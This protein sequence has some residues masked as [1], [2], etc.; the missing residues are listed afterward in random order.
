MKRNIL[1]A[2]FIVLT[3]T[4]HAQSPKYVSPTKFNDVN[5]QLLSL[6]T[7]YP[8]IAIGEGQHNSALTAEWL[9]SFIH[10]KKFSTKVRNIVVE[11]G[12][13]KYQAVMDDFVNGKPVP[14]SLFRLCWRKT[15]QILVWDCPIYEQFFREVRT[16][17]LSLPVT[18]RIRVLLGDPPDFNSLSRDE[19]AFNVIEK[20]V[21]EKKQTALLL[22]GDMH[23]IRK[24]I[25]NNYASPETIDRNYLNLVQLIDL[26]YPGKAFS[27]FGSVNTTDAE[28]KNIM[29]KEN[30]KS[31]A[32]IFTEKSNLGNID[33]SVFYPYPIER[34]DMQS[35]LIDSSN[36]IKMPIKNI[37]NAILFR[38]KW[39]EQTANNI[40]TSDEIY[41]DTI[42]KNEIIEKAKKWHHPALEYLQFLWSP[43]YVMISDK[44]HSGDTSNLNTLFEELK[45][46]SPALNW[47]NILSN[48]GYNLMCKKDKK[49]AITIFILATQEFPYDDYAFVNLGNS[50][51]AK[52]D[53]QNA[54]AAYSKAVEL[55]PKNKISKE[56]LDNLLDK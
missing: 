26:K 31:P 13:S 27:I 40:P 5:K 6:F 3:S 41:A 14:D 9:N 29:E 32:L 10:N 43:A 34:F 39:A 20:E 4:G 28:T 24:S 56:K 23:F 21:F 52:G 1:I 11:F 2:I 38:G 25:F 46:A 54:I 35:Q 36:Y 47:A 17:N 16:I 50:Y 51:F 22:Y 45:T 15:S 37:V 55:N 48:M 19:N 7:T 42:Y 18:K 49:E 44:V 33:F 53:Y 12:T 30:V 8:I